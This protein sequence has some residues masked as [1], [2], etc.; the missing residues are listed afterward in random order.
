MAS[1]RPR[2]LSSDPDFLLLL[3]GDIEESDSED[4]FEGWLGLD[5]SPTIIENSITEDYEESF[6]PL[7]RRS[8]TLDSLEMSIVLP[9][10]RLLPHAST[11]DQ[12]PPLSSAEPYSLLN[13][14]PSPFSHF[15]NS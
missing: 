9:E 6:T 11:Y 10:S 2:T 13:P 12:P 1:F 14:S 5:D 8:H 4:E 15:I 7:R 3:I